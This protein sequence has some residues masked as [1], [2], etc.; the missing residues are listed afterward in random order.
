MWWVSGLCPGKSG[1]LIRCVL[2]GVVGQW[3][4]SGQVRWVDTLCP[5]RCG[6]WVDTLCPGRCGGSV[7]CVQVSQVG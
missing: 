3:V 7:G 6:R 5:G 1:G 4:V 2:V